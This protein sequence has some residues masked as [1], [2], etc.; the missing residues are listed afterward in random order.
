MGALGPGGDHVET[1]RDTVLA[2]CAPHYAWAVEST[3]AFLLR[4][5]PLAAVP[6]RWLS[7]HSC[8]RADGVKE[9]SNSVQ[10]EAGGRKQ[11]Q[12]QQEQREEEQ[13]QRQLRLSSSRQR[14]GKTASGT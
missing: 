14:N 2:M 11:A 3:G 1:G 7:A 5:S 10:Q 6:C 8:A 13:Q 9:G 4:A 12:A